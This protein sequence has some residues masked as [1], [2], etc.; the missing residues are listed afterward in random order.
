MSDRYPV[1]SFTGSSTEYQ[2]ITPENSSVLA[3][4]MR[5]RGLGR[6]IVTSADDPRRGWNGTGL[7]DL[8]DFTFLEELL[9]Y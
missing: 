2:V 6:L 7:P 8:K 5:D 4:Y 1:F 3:G 9:I